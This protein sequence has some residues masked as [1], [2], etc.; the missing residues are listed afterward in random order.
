MKPWNMLSA[1]GAVLLVGYLLPLFNPKVEG[2]TREDSKVP[3][4]HARDQTPARAVPALIVVGALLLPR[5]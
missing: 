4:W 2:A 3:W 5:S 1:F